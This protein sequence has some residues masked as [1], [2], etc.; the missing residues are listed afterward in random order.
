LRG[1]PKD[2]RRIVEAAMWTIQHELT[3]AQPTAGDETC[4]RGVAASPGRYTGPVRIVL[5]ES[6]LARLKPG[7]VESLLETTLQLLCR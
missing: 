7:E 4:L 5:E 6:D 3:P 2:A 1:L